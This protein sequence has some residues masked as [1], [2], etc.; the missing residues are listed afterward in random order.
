GRERGAGGAE[1]AQAGK[2]AML[3]GVDIGL[4]AVRV[5]GGAGP[6]EAHAGL[7]REAP[8]RPHVGPARISVVD[9]DGR[10]AEQAADLAVPHDPAGTGVPEETVLR[11]EVVVED[12]ELEMLEHHAAMAVDDGLGHA[13]GATRVDDPEW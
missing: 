10:A 1:S 4:D 8:Q 2:I 6:E 3:G 7:G 11:P 13:R 12:T 9:A 5:V